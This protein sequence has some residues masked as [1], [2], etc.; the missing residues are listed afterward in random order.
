M[1]Q[2]AFSKQEEQKTFKILRYYKIQT[3]CLLKP[4]LKPFIDQARQQWAYWIKL[5][6]L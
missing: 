2:P 4:L 1:G 5:Q 6:E 3:L